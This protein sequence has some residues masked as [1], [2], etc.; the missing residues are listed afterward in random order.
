MT[1]RHGLHPKTRCRQTFPVTRSCDASPE[2][3]WPDRRGTD[4]TIGLGADDSTCPKRRTEDLEV[5]DAPRSSPCDFKASPPMTLYRDN[6]NRSGSSHGDTGVDDDSRGLGDLSFLDDE[7]PNLPPGRGDVSPSSSSSD[8]QASSVESDDEDT[9]DEVQQ[10]KKAKKAKKKA[11]MK[12]RFDPPGSSLSDEKSLQRLRKKCEISKE[13][14]LVSPTLAD[15]VVAPSL[16]DRVV[17]PSLADRAVAPPP[18]HFTLFENYFDQ[19]LLWFPL[20]RFLR[21]FLAVH[22]VF[23]VQINPRDISHLLGIYVL[24]GNWRRSLSRKTIKMALSTE[25]IPGKIL[26]R[27]RARVSSREQAALEAASKAKG[28]LGTNMPRV[29]IPMTSTPMAPSVRARS[30]RPLAPKTPATSTILPPPSSGKLAEFCRLLAERARISSGK[31]KGVDRETP[32]KRQRVDTYPAA[33]QR[34]MLLR[35]SLLSLFFDRLVG[36][37]DEDVCSRDSELRAAKEASAVLQSRLDE[38]A[39]RNEVLERDVLS[40]QKIKKN[41]DDKLTK[42]KSRCT[43]G[44]VVRLRGELSYPSDLQRTKIS[45]AVA[46][47]RPR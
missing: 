31:G 21:R 37:Y 44:E 4:V 41:C 46:E 36:D 32:S 17:A 34:A 38:F 12:V 19:C 16:A 2:T 27:G 9:L 22:G 14:V 11:K 29:V 7:S 5:T 33:L 10:T 13:I 1:R 28:S 40:V 24:N 3:R 6:T 15:R 18:G 47:A 35:L 25:I 8:L 43:K 23:L 30:S 20:P 42:L 39:E 45:E 26:G